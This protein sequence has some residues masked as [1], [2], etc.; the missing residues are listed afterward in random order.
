MG[1]R[2]LQRVAAVNARGKKQC[3]YKPALEG[4]GTTRTGVVQQTG[5]PSNFD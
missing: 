2:A 1:T 5:T 3:V 4:G